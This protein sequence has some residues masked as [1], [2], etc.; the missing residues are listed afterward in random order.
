[1]KRSKAT[2]WSYSIDS[3]N[4]SYSCSYRTSS[5]LCQSHSISACVQNF[6]LR[7]FQSGSARQC[8]SILPTEQIHM[9]D[10]QVP[11]YKGTGE[12]LLRVCQNIFSHISWN[13]L[14]AS[15]NDGT[16]IELT[17]QPIRFTS[18]L[19]SKTVL[20]SVLFLSGTIAV[21][22]PLIPSV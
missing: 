20:L 6:A 7:S 9:P 2:P 19:S 18:S 22:C 15:A 5:Y 12:P 8:P 1:M 16:C 13:L 10:F 17:R 21:D 4:F 14:V 3:F 11:S